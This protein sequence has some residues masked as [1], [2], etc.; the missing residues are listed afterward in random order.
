[1]P[2][3]HAIG[4]LTFCCPG[5]HATT[6]KSYE[7][8]VSHTLFGCRCGLVSPFSLDEIN[9]LPGA[10]DTFLSKFESSDFNFFRR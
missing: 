3:N 10:H 2:F 9:S 8:A 7:W 5:C 1:M 6:I 4:S